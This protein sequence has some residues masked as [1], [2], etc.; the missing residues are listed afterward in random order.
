MGLAP[1]TE[2]AISS[3]QIIPEGAGPGGNPGED[4][5]AEDIRT[6]QEE[7]RSR[8]AGNYIRWTLES[9]QPNKYPSTSRS[10]LPHALRHRRDPAVV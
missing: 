8:A 9:E 5:P 6:R 4:S 1:G 10:H 3:F 2:H 7:G